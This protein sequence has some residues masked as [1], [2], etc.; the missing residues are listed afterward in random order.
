MGRVRRIGTGLVL[1]M[2]G[3]LLASLS[4]LNYTL[5]SGTRVQGQT[6]VEGLAVAAPLLHYQGRLLDPATGN[7]KPDGNY[8][9]IFSLYD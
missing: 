6:L 5:I 7:P 9:M 4:P 8:S 2:I 3:V 1:V